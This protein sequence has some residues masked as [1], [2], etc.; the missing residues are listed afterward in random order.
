MLE[1]LIEQI[2][3][4]EKKA[5]DMV[6][7]SRSQ[8]REMVKG[9]EIALSEAMRNN[10]QDNRQYL[11][12]TIEKARR[13]F[14]VILEEISKEKKQK[15]QLKIDKYRANIDRV[16]TNIVKRVLTNGNC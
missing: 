3:L 14:S 5:N 11:Q 7:D 6:Q 15:E 10:S 12:E 4:E 2:K 13:D 1:S 9:V 8:A 16:S